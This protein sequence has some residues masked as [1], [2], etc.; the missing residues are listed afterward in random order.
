MSRLHIN[1]GNQGKLRILLIF[2]GIVNLG[3]LYLVAFTLV[4]QVPA[5]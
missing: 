1:M 4:A 2:V 3:K 5:S